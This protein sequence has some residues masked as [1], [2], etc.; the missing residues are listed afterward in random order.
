MSGRIDQ[1][2]LTSSALAGNRPGDPLTRLVTVILPPAYAESQ[3]RYPAL[4]LLSSHGNTGPGMLN[5]QPWGESLPEQIARLTAA[6]QLAPV[7]VVLPDMW[8]RYGS[9]QFINSEGIGRYEDYLLEIVAAVDARYRTRPSRDHRGVLGRS[10]GGYGAL[11]QAMR[12][13]E[14]FGAVACHS[15]D[16]YWEYTCLPA[17]AR[18]HQQLA[19]YGGLEA[20]IRDI[21]AIRPKGGT[22]WELVMTLCWAAAFGG[23]PAAPH[24]FDLPIDPETGAL[25]S[26]VWARW[27]AH[28]PLRMI[29]DP[30]H[31][32]ALRQARL[33]F[34]DAGQFDEYQLQVGARLLHRKLTA[35]AV[36]HLYEEYP[37]GHRHTQYRLDR[38]LPLLA[39]ALQ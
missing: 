24:G 21:P 9:S 15:G 34:V 12:H 29:D 33:V 32:A 23:N 6:G 3:Q 31:A 4:Y 7:I 27:L 17:L 11:V 5:W 14:I 30:A 26:A 38:S 37:D 8:T 13:P 36:P 20:F 2:W 22:F 25:D 16:L 18:L 10:S 35:L 28:D 19:Q 1:F 39:E